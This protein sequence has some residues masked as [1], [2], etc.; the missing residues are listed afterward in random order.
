MRNRSTR[1]GSEIEAVAFAGGK[2]NEFNIVSGA[3]PAQIANHYAFVVL[4]GSS[5]RAGPLVCWPHFFP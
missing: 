3:K 2:M 5:P 1:A 4:C